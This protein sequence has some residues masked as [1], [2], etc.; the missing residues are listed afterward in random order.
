MFQN[1]RDIRYFLACLPFDHSVSEFHE[2]GL[3]VC[4][5]SMTETYRARTYVILYF[6]TMLFLRNPSFANSTLTEL[7]CKKTLTVC[8]GSVI[9][10]ERKSEKRPALER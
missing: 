10:K 9:A 2:I 3:L 7:C 4:K 6:R 1:S 5:K 8:N